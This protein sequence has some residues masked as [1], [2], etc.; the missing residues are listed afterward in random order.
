M[1]HL[2][3]ENV[4]IYKILIELNKKRYNPKR[5]IEEEIQQISHND[6]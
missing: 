1:S 3:L 4:S 6:V 2:S 5:L